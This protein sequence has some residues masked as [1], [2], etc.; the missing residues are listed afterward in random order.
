MENR[1][2]FESLFSIEKIIG[3][4]GFGSILKVKKKSNDSFWAAK[5]LPSDDAI[6]ELRNLL[7]T[8]PHNNVV[9]SKETYISEDGKTWYII[10]KLYTGTLKEYQNQEYQ[11]SKKLMNEK[12][13]VEIIKRIA[14]GLAHLHENGLTHRDLKPQNILYDIKSNNFVIAD[15]GISKFGDKLETQIG[16]QYYMAPEILGMNKYDCKV[17]IW[18]FGCIVF[19]LMTNRYAFECIANQSTQ[20][21][22]FRPDEEF[23]DDLKKMVLS[24]FHEPKLRP[25]AAEILTTITKL[26]KRI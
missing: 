11:N 20:K 3:S 26:E 16:T 22:L 18:S 8:P 19:E 10:L 17:D 6:N 23:S 21:P 15:L 24:C 25:S 12:K 5:S 14:S 7:V 2:T 9:S 4:G 13:V 1:T